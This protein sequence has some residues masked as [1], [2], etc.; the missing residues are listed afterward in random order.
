MIEPGR[1]EQWA[2]PLR[3]LLKPV[4]IVWAGVAVFWLFIWRRP[5]WSYDDLRFATRSGT[6]H[7]AVAWDQLWGQI[8]YDVG[9]RVGRTADVV[10]ELVFSTGPLIGVLMAAFCVAQAWAMWRLL[11][12]AVTGEGGQRRRVLE[13]AACAA[14]IAVPLALLGSDPGLAGSTVLFMSANV[15]YVLGTALMMIAMVLLWGCMSSDRDRLWQLALVVL[16]C[17]FVAMHHELLALGLAGWAIGT[18]LAMGRKHWSVVRAVALALVLAVGLGRYSA[19]GLWRRQETV[20]PPFVHDPLP[21]VV[22]RRTYVVHSVTQNLGQLPGLYIAFALAVLALGV[23]GAVRSGRRR[24]VVVA[25]A[26]FGVGCVLMTVFTVGVRRLLVHVNGAKDR[27]NHSDRIGNAQVY[28]SRSGTEV[29]VATAFTVIALLW[30]GWLLRD[31]ERFR[32]VSPLIWAT[33]ALFSLPTLTG[34]PGD[35]V[36]YVPLLFLMVT[37]AA[38]ALVALSNTGAT[39]RELW[40]AGLAGIAIAISVGPAPQAGGRLVTAVDA[41]IAAWRPVRIQIE[42]AQHG[43]RREILIPRT[44]AEPTYITDNPV[45]RGEYKRLITQYYDLPGSVTIG[46]VGHS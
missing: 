26:M 40:A 32:I 25:T 7:G 9:E 31:V 21:P 45:S 41:N 39:G 14:G 34:S 28:L 17:F 8:R 46:L 15:G 27:L 22:E 10:G 20:L 35:R 5:I 12:L 43:E 29:L 2:A 18:A 6:T 44:L 16:L 19:T 11:R 3:R 30:M 1:S 38:T 4:V 24:L 42:Q 37:T 23:A 13:A 33:V 36:M